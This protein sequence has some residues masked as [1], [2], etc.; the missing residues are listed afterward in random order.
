MPNLDF[1]KNKISNRS[2]DYDFYNHILELLQDLYEDKDLKGHLHP[3]GFT[4]IT[5]QNWNNNE[6]LRIHIWAKEGR[7][8]N[9]NQ[10][11]IHNHEYSV[12][13]LVLLGNL[14]NT[15]YKI[16]KD[17]QNRSLPIFNVAYDRMNSD[18]V[19][20]NDTC[21]ISVISNDNLDFGQFY[22]IPNWEFHKVEVPTNQITCT[23]VWN[24]DKEIGSPCVL[25][26]DNMNQKFLPY[27]RVEYNQEQLRMLLYEV[28]TY[29]KAV[30]YK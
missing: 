26:T 7:K 15:K 19:L 30:I 5:L 21:D 22:Y 29:I 12:F 6:R 10:S 25:G 27:E 20:T 17:S 28:I 2:F 16:I 24:F 13:S 11:W 1:I 8:Y 23:L 3:L 18:L 14:L 4:I 9:N